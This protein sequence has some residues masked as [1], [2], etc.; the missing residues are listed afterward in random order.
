MPD[1][2][3][4][5]KKLLL[6]LIKEVKKMLQEKP[7]FFLNEHDLSAYLYSQLLEIPELKLPFK[8][9]RDGIE[10]SCYRVHVEYPRYSI[11]NEKLRSVGKY[12]VAILRQEN[13]LE[14]PFPKDEFTKKSVWVGFEVKLHW[15]AGLRKVNTSVK[16]E[17]NAFAK[18]VNCVTR[19][20]ADYGV[21]FHLNIDR[22]KESA[23]KV[24]EGNFKDFQNQE[25]VKDSQV[26]IV[27]MES[28]NEKTKGP[29]NLAV[30]PDGTKFL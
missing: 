4:E 21:V 15:D 27:Y 12:D 30:M 2:V 17:M 28:Y 6:D 14:D 26:F 18:M 29:N 7:F 1:D 25:A 23:F 10:H 24:I 20:P 13:T 16:S 3:K 22:K 9:E 5:I 11:E 8:M 19:I